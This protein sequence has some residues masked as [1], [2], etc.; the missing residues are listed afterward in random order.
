MGGVHYTMPQ[1]RASWVWPAF[2]LFR[3]TM[4]GGDMCM[5]VGAGEGWSWH[6]A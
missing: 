6:M 3:L 2:S 4:G 1:R 5:Y